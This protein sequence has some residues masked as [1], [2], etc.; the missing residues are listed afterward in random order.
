MTLSALR[1][2]TLGP[3]TVAAVDERRLLQALLAG[4]AGKLGG[5]DGFL[6]GP[7]TGK[8]VRVE[9]CASALEHLVINGTES[10][11]QGAYALFLDAVD[12]SVVLDSAPST[13]NRIDLVL[14]Y[15]QDDEYSTQSGHSAGDYE[16]VLTKLTGTEA[17]SPVAPDPAAAGFENWHVLAQVLRT[18]GEPA[19]LASSAFTDLRGQTFPGDYAFIN[20]VEAD[21]VANTLTLD[22]PTA[23]FEHF[24]IR[25]VVGHSGTSPDGM[26]TRFNGDSGS[27]YNNLRTWTIMGG[28][29]GQAGGR[30][31]A[32]VFSR[33]GGTRGPYRLEIFEASRTF[34]GFM[35]QIRVVDGGADIE[36]QQQILDGRYTNGPITSVQ[37]ELVS[38]VW[39]GGSRL[40]LYGV[41]RGLGAA[42]GG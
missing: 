34:N 35:A 20:R 40:D 2:H 4:V 41:R 10:A 11:L 5:G 38:E 19:D 12:T 13:N 14:A 22:L 21:G 33:V 7:Q 26:W 17:A 32:G 42:M 18:P 30:T 39:S 25:G 37:L 28:N 3:P 24:V 29:T 27:N 16:P 36:N 31:E 15:V 6:C 8:T 9:A 23:Q 1:F